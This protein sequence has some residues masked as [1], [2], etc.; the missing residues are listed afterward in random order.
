MTMTYTGV[1][2]V[3]T[4]KLDAYLRMT[5]ERK[6]A[7]L[8]KQGPTASNWTTNALAAGRK[9]LRR[10]EVNE[11]STEQNSA[12][13]NDSA[14]VQ[15]FETLSP[16]SVKRI[17][18][19]TNFEQVVNNVYDKFLQTVS[20]ISPIRKENTQRNVLQEHDDNL[21]HRGPQR[22]LYKGAAR[23]QECEHSELLV[24]DR[25]TTINNNDNDSIDK[26]GIFDSFSKRHPMSD[27]IQ[28]KSDMK[29]TQQVMELDMNIEPTSSADLH[30]A[31]IDS[32]LESI[33]QLR[34]VLDEDDKDEL[35]MS[36]SFSQTSFDDG[37]Q[38][39]ESI[40]ASFS[41]SNAESSM[42]GARVRNLYPQLFENR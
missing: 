12:S 38:L 2:Y 22:M 21:A 5:R 25:P 15:G 29:H 33:A 16:F 40:P 14:H 39:S 3:A 28:G 10:E 9:E 6:P 24:G 11:V 17:E 19:N 7:F 13:Q 34:K 18:R 42:T 23:E 20:E 30:D 36:Q 35:N 41:N 8:Q 37:R 1:R 26:S 31:K 4:E 32:L 27:G